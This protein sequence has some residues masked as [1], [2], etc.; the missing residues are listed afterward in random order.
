MKY[1]EIPSKTFYEFSSVK[2]FIYVQ[3]A[4]GQQLSV[5][6]MSE[7]VKD[8]IVPVELSLLPFSFIFETQQSVQVILIVSFVSSGMESKREWITPGFKKRGI[9]VFFLHSFVEFYQSA[10]QNLFFACLTE[11]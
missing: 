5:A 3:S 9:L 8:F 4:V 10:Q 7:Q 6:D 11:D 1:F 2:A